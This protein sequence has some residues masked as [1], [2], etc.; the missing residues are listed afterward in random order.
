MNV[1]MGYQATRR[2]FG[3]FLLR[4]WLMKAMPVIGFGQREYALLLKEKE[5]G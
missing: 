3:C 4:E 5:E 2:Y 1:I